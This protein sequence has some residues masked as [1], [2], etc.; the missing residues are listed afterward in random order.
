MVPTDKYLKP[1]LV[2]SSQLIDMTDGLD[3]TSFGC[4]K[5]EEAFFISFCVLKEWAPSN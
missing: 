2:V 3:L 1:D 5:G 4:K